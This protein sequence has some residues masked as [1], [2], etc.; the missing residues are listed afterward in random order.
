MW[1][2]RKKL[3]IATISSLIFL[4]GC[5][6]NSP[7]IKEIKSELNKSFKDCQLINISD[8]K[9]LNGESVL[10]NKYIVDISYQINF[11]PLQDAQEL[12]LQA[13]Q[14]DDDFEREIEQ[15]RILRGDLDSELNEINGYLNEVHA[16][17]NKKIQDFFNSPEFM[18]KSVSHLEYRTAL[19]NEVFKANQ[20]AEIRKSQLNKE[21]NEIDRKILFTQSDGNKIRKK[22]AEDF[23]KTCVFKTKYAIR[24]FTHG[25]ITDL[26][27]QDELPLGGEFKFTDSVSM[28]LTE[29][30]WLFDI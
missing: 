28:K 20:D 15:L 27:E 29:K 6:D 9:K 23:N 25:V 30:G 11:T 22:I 21:I 13:K 5:G 19:N 24:V 4:V 18:N 14:M 17:A 26:F 10:N 3:S 2:N 1:F 8:V 16:A 7:S 12:Y